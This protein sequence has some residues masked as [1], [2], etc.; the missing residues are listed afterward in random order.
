MNRLPDISIVIPCFNVERYIEE[1]VRSVE[2]ACGL[3]HEIIAVDNGSTDGTLNVLHSLQKEVGALSIV[4]TAE[5]GASHARNK[6]LQLAKG[7]YI[8]FLDADDLLEPGKLDHQWKLAHEQGAGI[9][10]A[11]YT[12]LTTGLQHLP[13]PVAPSA[14]LGLF[15]TRLGITSSCLF[16]THAVRQV[17]GWDASL[18]SSQEYDLMFRLMRGGV[19]VLLD[20]EPLTIVRDREEGQISTSDPRPR[21]KQYVELRAD[22]LDTMR[23]LKVDEFLINE[24]A[25][26]RAFYDQLHIAFKYQPALCAAMYKRYLGAGFVPMPSSAVAP[27]FVRLHKALGFVWAERIKGWMKRA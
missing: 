24:E 21:W 7:E 5:R 23:N 16:Q 14:W 22:I 4:Q 1:A 8:Q 19:Q 18:K 26:M 11:S 12:R 25:F 6:G 10:A 17:H 27:S 15:T 20:T 3:E 9:V 2:A 13:V